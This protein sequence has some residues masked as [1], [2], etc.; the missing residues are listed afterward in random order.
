[1]IYIL[2]IVVNYIT[3]FLFISYLSLMFYQNPTYNKFKKLIVNNIFNSFI[4]RK[5]FLNMYKN[6]AH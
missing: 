5:L 3:C 1:M 4:L 6:S 2:I